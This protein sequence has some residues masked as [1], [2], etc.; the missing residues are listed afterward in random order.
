MPD[1]PSAI[2]DD[3]LLRRFLLGDAT[4]EERERV[5]RHL[6]EDAAGLERIEAVED[7]LLDAG[8][9]G[10]LAADERARLAATPTGR[11]RL[12]FAED[13]AHL[14]DGLSDTQP[15]FV[16]PVLTPPRR[17]AVARPRRAA[18][19]AAAA[20]LAAGLAAIVV[21]TRPWTHAGRPAGTPG[22]SAAAH[23]APA[24]AP[25]R[26][27]STLRPGEGGL[28][29]PHPLAIAALELTLATERGGAATPRRRIPPGTEGVEL[30][31]QLEKEESY[32]TYRAK[33]LDAGGRTVASAAGLSPRPAA[34]GPEIVLPVPA[35]SLPPGR[36]EV[37][38][39]VGF[40]E[41]VVVR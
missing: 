31:I 40:P 38:V 36:Y 10:E 26:P 4:A 14:S 6:V 12:A 16:P 27:P 1:D 28:P 29:A 2:P 41:F 13:L 23:P 33:V 8:A 35:A 30:R 3:A 7:E 37:A 32:P 11:R 9:R 25:S 19:F 20:A 22:A 24:A 39:E 34:G 17:R 18:A 15:A 21:G 5:E